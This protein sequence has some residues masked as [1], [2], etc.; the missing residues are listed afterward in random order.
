MESKRQQWER[1]T[2]RKGFEKTVIVEG[3]LTCIN[4]LR[5]T[6]RVFIKMI[7]CIA[8]KVIIIR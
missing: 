6:K 2:S 4:K 1:K 8:T 3:R 7:A 5:S